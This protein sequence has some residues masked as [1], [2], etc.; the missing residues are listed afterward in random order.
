MRMRKLFALALVG[1]LATT[2]ALA[3]MG[4]GN[5]A[6]ESTP[7]TSES[8]PSNETM[9]SDTTM[10]DTSMADTTMHQ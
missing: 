1:L 10:S 2:V 8:A 3:V 6:Q 7:A 4:C 5:K 9:M